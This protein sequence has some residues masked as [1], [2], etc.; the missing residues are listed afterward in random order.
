MKFLK[1]MML[2]AMAAGIVS[3]QASAQT[4]VTVTFNG[5]TA[6]HTNNNGGAWYTLIQSGDL[7]VNLSNAIVYCID[8]TRYFQPGSSYNNYALYSFNDFLG[9]VANSASPW[10]PNKL[11]LDNLNSMA[12]LTS[13]YVVGSTASFDKVT[14]TNVQQAIWNISNN[15]VNPAGPPSFDNSGWS[16]LYNGQNQTF[17]V[18][19]PPRFQTPEP[20]TFA[21]LASGLV[22]LVAVGRRRNS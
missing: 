19:T 15:A 14:N 11:T 16:V 9:S 8:N 13:S 5:G 12:D 3:T 18:Q 6:V 4:P 7:T 17:L 20:A 22:G 10:A 21:L 2:A 1:S